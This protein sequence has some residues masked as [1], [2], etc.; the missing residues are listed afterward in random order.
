MGTSVNAQ[1]NSNSKYVNASKNACNVIIERTFSI[2]KQF[3]LLY[4]YSNTY[5]LQNESLDVL[6]NFTSSVIA[7]KKKEWENEL[8][9]K[10]AKKETGKSEEQPE[11]LGIK[12]RMAFLDLLLHYNQEYGLLSD[13]D[14]REEVDTFMFEVLLLLSIFNLQQFW[15]FCF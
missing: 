2:W 4:R 11:D 10:Q 6:H 7:R 1:K 13:A 15:Y 14:I 12:K 3:D 5:K 9:E 8:K